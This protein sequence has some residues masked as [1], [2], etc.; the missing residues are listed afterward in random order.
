MRRPLERAVLTSCVGEVLRRH[1]NVEFVYK[2]QTI[3]TGA[4]LQLVTPSGNHKK[5]PTE[6]TLRQ[7]FVAM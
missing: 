5:F 1:A 3:S 6:S 7:V 4:F 2:V